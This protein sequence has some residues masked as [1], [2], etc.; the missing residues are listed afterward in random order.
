MKRFASFS[1][2]LFVTLTAMTAV[3]Q[4]PQAVLS[5]LGSATW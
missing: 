4:V 1:M 3:A 2:L 5:E